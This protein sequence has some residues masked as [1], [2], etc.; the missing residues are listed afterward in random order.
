MD[1]LNLQTEILPQRKPFKR[2]VVA[3][4]MFA[5]GRAWQT[6]YRV[7]A[8][9]QREVQDWPEG[10]QVMFKV[11]PCGP[12]FVMQKTGG[13]LRYCGQQGH[14]DEMDLI[15]YLK[16]IESAFMVMTAQMGIARA[17]AE[18]RMSVTG[19]LRYGLAVVRSMNIV[20][21]YIF[22]SLIAGRTIKRPV[23]IHPVRKHVARLLTYFVGIP[24]GL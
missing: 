6:L 23:E 1:T 15:I 22:P 19:D 17:Y 18:H 16:N 20:E 5:L 8:R 3:S 11:R 10:F 13:R 14:A 24:F 21:S 4:A 12:Q 7:D 2:A 9:L